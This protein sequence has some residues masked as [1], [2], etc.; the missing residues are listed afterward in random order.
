MREREKE[1]EKKRERVSERERENE[2]V[3]LKSVSR[4][5][6]FMSTSFFGLGVVGVVCV[7]GVVGVV[8][9]F[10]ASFP[11]SVRY[12]SSASTQFRD[13]RHLDP[14]FAPFSVQNE[15]GPAGGNCNRGRLDS[16]PNRT[17]KYSPTRQLVVVYSD[18][19]TSNQ[20]EL[21]TKNIINSN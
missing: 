7:V 8:V 11:R 13:C 17:G 21:R 15:I 19:C 6:K 12:K 18:N 1:R 14:S 16:L 9:G 10:G 20:Y 3:T 4:E 2:K 5:I